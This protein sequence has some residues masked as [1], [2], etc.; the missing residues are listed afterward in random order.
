MNTKRGVTQERMNCCRGLARL[1]PRR[2]RMAL[3]LTFPSRVVRRESSYNQPCA[4]YFCIEI[5]MSL[6]ARFG[7]RIR[8]RCRAPLTPRSRPRLSRANRAACLALALWTALM[9]ARSD[10]SQQGDAIGMTG[11]ARKSSLPTVDERK[12]AC[13]STS[14]IRINCSH[15][16]ASLKKS[17]CSA[18][19]VSR[20][21]R[22][23]RPRHVSTCQRTSRTQYSTN[24][25]S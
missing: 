21:R 2:R 11:L 3:P 23:Q 8:V 9:C 24:T 22:V 7:A 6:A 19:A 20:W 15:F 14:G 4:E 13:S 10:D 18:S 5:C 16:G 25:P 17:I 1:R 12:A